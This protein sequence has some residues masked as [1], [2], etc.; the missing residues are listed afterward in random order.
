MK[1][2]I[3]FVLLVV[4]VMGVVP[5]AFAKTNKYTFGKK[6]SSSPFSFELDDSWSINEIEDM[7]YSFL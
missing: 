7:T 2:I 1:K 6:A 3:A 4:L 5:P